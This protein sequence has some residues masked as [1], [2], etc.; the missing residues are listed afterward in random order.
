MTGDL[1]WFI[2]LLATSIAAAKL[3]DD[4]RVVAVIVLAVTFL[5]PSILRRIFPVL[6]S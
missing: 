6:R 4:E 3:F 5:G 1:L 2:L